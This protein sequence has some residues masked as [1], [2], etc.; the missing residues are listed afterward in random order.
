M[1]IQRKAMSES[2]RVHRKASQGHK[3]I[4]PEVVLMF[5]DE[6]KTYLQIGDQKLDGAKRA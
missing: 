1:R 6:H 5:E 3:T 4:A 2:A